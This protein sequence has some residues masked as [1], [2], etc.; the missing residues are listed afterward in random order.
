[1]TGRRQQAWTN[2]AS[3]SLP[4]VAFKEML[5]RLLLLSTLLEQV[6]GVL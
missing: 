5:I 6:D 3:L 1:M 2:D 4:P